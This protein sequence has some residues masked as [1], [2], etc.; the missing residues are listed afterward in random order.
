MESAS[1]SSSEH[2]HNTTK[3]NILLKTKFIVITGDIKT[4]ILHKYLSAYLYKNTQTNQTAV[5]TNINT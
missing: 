3:T 4:L 5:W 2:S 1:S